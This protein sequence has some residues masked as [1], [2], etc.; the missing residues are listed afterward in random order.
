[1]IKFDDKK[2]GRINC[3]RALLHHFEYKDKNEK[4]ACEP[5]PA[6]VGHALNPEFGK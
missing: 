2:R 3:I 5:N 4:A 6:I 1:M